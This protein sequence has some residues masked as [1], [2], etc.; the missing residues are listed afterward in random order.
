MNP[1]LIAKTS[2]SFE[3]ASSALL[4]A[5]ST[6]G[7]GVMAVH[8]LG[9][10]LRN[11]GIDFAEECRIYEVCNPQQAARVLKDEMG[12]NMAL[13]CRISV[14]TEA[15]QTRI[16]MIRPEGMLRSLS[17]NPALID[18]AREVEASTTAIIEAAAS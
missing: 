15:G 9:Q 13:P 8:D 6:N 4:S 11:K 14:Y 5:I 1:F 3:E 18:V 12:L 2:K 7:F 17:S 10:T 16:G